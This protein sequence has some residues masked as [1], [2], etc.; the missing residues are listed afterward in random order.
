VCGAQLG[1]RPC[2][3]AHLAPPPQ[4][5]APSSPQP[6]P[7]LASAAASNAASV[8]LAKA[9]RLVRLAKAARLVRLAKA[10]RPL[11]L[12]LHRR[13]RLT[14]GSPPTRTMGASCSFT[15]TTPLPP[16][17]TSAVSP[18]LPL[19]F[20]RQTPATKIILSL[21]HPA[22]TRP[23]VPSL[24]QAPKRLQKKALDSQSEGMVWR[25]TQQPPEH[26]QL[27]RLT[28]PRWSS[29]CSAMPA[30]A[31]VRLVCSTSELLCLWPR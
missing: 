4:L 26:D 31:A 24:L 25:A 30:P 7:A 11:Q 8:R 17:C 12:C 13:P 22:T 1:F 18:P 3:M 19:L 21:E 2:F 16:A 14:A 5:L 6:L 10:A 28:C 20:Y 29:R 23:P 15:I 9:A 27:H